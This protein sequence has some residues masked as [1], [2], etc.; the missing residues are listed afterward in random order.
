MEPGPGSGQ[1][2]RGQGRVRH[3]RQRP[4]HDQADRGGGLLRLGA[5]LGQ[6]DRPLVGSRSGQNLL[7]QI[8]VGA[9]YPGGDRSQV[10]AGQGGGVEIAA[11]VVTRFRGPERTVF[12]A[13]LG[14]GESERIRA[15]DGSGRILAALDRGPGESRRHTADVLRVEDVDGTKSS[16]YRGGQRV[17]VRFG[18]GSDD[19]AGIT[20]DD[21][22]QERGLIRPRRRHH[23]QVLLQRNTQTVPVMSAAQEHRVLPGIQEAV[24][25]RKRRAD[26]A[27]APQRGQAAPAQP[28]TEHVGEALA[29]MQPQVQAEPHVSDAVAGQMSGR[30][31]RPLGESRPRRAR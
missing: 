4:R 1:H 2:R 19:R 5:E 13:L 21:V 24:E 6:S 3:E 20:Q 22:S 12:D 18:G 26:P 10:I 14:D 25:Q 8:R 31:E 29:R 11:Q 15:A 30:Q 28:Q 17:D 16:A 27:G 23:Q 9:G 7:R